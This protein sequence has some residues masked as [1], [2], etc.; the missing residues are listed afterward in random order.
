MVRKTD[1]KKLSNRSTNTITPSLF[2]GAFAYV[3]TNKL[4][5]DEING[6]WGVFAGVTVSTLVK[7][8]LD[9]VGVK[10]Q[11]GDD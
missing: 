1:N 4:I 8:L 2:A 3:I 9:Q 7:I 6:W 5:D 11:F 10:D